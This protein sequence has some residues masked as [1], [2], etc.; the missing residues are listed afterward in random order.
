MTT[1]PQHYAE[2]ERLLT[3]ADHFTDQGDTDIGIA[4]AVLAH[5]H[6]LLAQAA[7][8]G[9]AAAYPGGLPIAD[10]YEWAETA[11]VL[12]APALDIRGPRGPVRPQDPFPILAAALRDFADEH[13]LAA[14]FTDPTRRDRIAGH[15]TAAL[16]ADRTDGIPHVPPP[17]DG[18]TTP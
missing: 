12:H 15:L 3:R 5:G 7:A 17:P 9:L 2:A 16:L 4:V 18:T 10:Y 1:G 11:S 14:E 13:P 6:A 8:A